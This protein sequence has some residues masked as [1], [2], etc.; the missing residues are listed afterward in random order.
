MKK[1]LSLMLTLALI[2][3]TIAVPLSAFADV[4][5]AGNADGKITVSYA[6]DKDTI[7]PGD[8]FTVTVN[9]SVS[10]LT[11]AGA[12][13]I[14]V[15]AY[16]IDTKY[17]ATK[18]EFA[19]QAV[20]GQL[21]TAIKKGTTDNYVYMI[22]EILTVGT[23][24]TKVGSFKFKARAAATG[25]DVLSTLAGNTMFV[26]DSDAAKTYKYVGGSATV[27]FTPNSFSV[28]D[29]NTVMQDGKNYYG[30]QTEKLYT[31]TGTNITNV[32]VK[33]GDAPV[34]ATKAV[35]SDDYTF[36][37]PALTE[38]NSSVTYT[39]KVTQVGTEGTIT[40][41]NYYEAVDVKI[42]IDT[43]DGKDNGFIRSVEGTDTIISV[44]I[45]ISGVST[46]VAAAMVSFKIEADAGLTYSSV[47]GDNVTY[48]EA[49]K[50]VVFN[51]NTSATE[52]TITNAGVF[53]TVKFKVDPEAAY[54]V[55]NIRIS[56]PNLA[57]AKGIGGEADQ[58]GIDKS[59]E[60]VIV[61]PSGDF[62]TITV[63]ENQSWTN[64]TYNNTVTAADTAVGVRFGA[65]A[66]DGTV[67]GATKDTFTNATG[68]VGSNG[69]MAIGGGNDPTTSN[70]YV[71][72][73]VG[74]D[75]NAI[76]KIYDLKLGEKV[77][78]DNTK[79]AVDVT[80]VKFEGVQNASSDVTLDVSGLAASKAT[81][82]SGLNTL[83]YKLDGNYVDV[84]SFDFS[85]ES[86]TITITGDN[87]KNYNGN[88]TFKVTDKAGNETESASVALK[89][90]A[91]NPEVT[92]I[93]V[94][95]RDA[96]GY[97]TL[98]PT[99][100]DQGTEVTKVAYTVKAYTQAIS[101]NAISS[102]EDIEKLIELPA[103]DSAYKVNSPYRVYFVVTDAA[104]HKGYN[105][106]EVTFDS[107]APSGIKVKTYAG[108]TDWISGFMPESENNALTPY[109]KT[110]G[111][112]IYVSIKVNDAANG[113]RNTV[114]ITK[115]SDSGS[116]TVS[117]TPDE[118]TGAYVFD[119]NA[120]GTYTFTVKTE[121]ETYS[122]DSAT[123]S[124]TFSIAAD[125]DAMLSASGDAWYNILDWQM[126][127]K[128]LLNENKYPKENNG[129]V[130]GYFSGDLDG[131][132]KYSTD[133]QAEIIRAITS[134]ENPGYYSFK[135][136][137]G[138]TK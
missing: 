9:A 82:L 136:M 50:T 14:N 113:Y 130:G 47:A 40:F 76:Y 127:K 63:P 135:I 11:D 56:A 31:I 21:G 16:T 66:Q 18:L 8:E 119:N 5:G 25:T 35:D 128:A 131:D 117:I 138:I 102:I 83:A 64:N 67:P 86:K 70:Y 110:N 124:Y 99:I 121:N 23:T 57:I 78:F 4:T 74:D 137:N 46:N 62:A 111:T 107:A 125:Q 90:D 65:Y 108:A 24:A 133:D 45:R 3:T 134:G 95:D 38:E 118:K 58:I 89:M 112:Y 29:D 44:P 36:T 43:I 48:K 61:I 53:A 34:E 114:T 19:S 98:A 123:E 60:K 27:S 94:G 7:H 26:D 52:T 39:V 120:S 100:T 101:E 41:T 72:A 59:E 88:I 84:E 49:D 115:K 28:K 13:S 37:A 20:S 109:R 12:T 30:V 68:T 55:K 15:A 81:G 73:R 106:T 116:E 92:Q 33:K 97:K 51:D 77:W 105:S 32:E 104:N 17:D 85:A 22:G 129:F 2:V 79:P 71:I 91:D 96:Q 122:G 93:T 42:G 132:L 80:N 10:D 69:E 1:F 6:V 126:I 87:L 103:T 75:N 54:G